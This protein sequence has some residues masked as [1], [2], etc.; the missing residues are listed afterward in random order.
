ME[1]GGNE[2]AV[3]TLRAKMGLFPLAELDDSSTA[4]DTTLVGSFE[5]RAE[6]EEVAS[7]LVNEGFTP[8]ID[9]DDGF[10]VHVAPGEQARALDVLA[11]RLGVE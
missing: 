10:A 9:T 7:I 5:S 1:E 11:E 6:A 4:E 2:I 8:H 3:A